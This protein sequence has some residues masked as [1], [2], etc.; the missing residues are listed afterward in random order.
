M[1]VRVWGSKTGREC[2]GESVRE[3]HRDYV[4]VR[5]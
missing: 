2:E 5:V 4:T 3:Q 1:T